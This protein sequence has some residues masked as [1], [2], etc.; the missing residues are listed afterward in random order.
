MYLGAHVL[1][2]QGFDEHPDARY[3]LVI[4]HGHFPAT[5][6]GFRETPPDPTWRRSARTASHIDG[7]NRVEQD[8]AYQSLQGLDRPELPALHPVEIQHAN[9][10][11]DDSYA[12]NSQN[13]GRTA[14]RSRTS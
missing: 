8:Y 13:L 11:Y 6:D 1:L 7:Y 4:Y 12:V 10:Y 5:F 2:P 9:P 3:P 14:T